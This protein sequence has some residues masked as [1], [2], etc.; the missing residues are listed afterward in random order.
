MT[1]SNV[2]AG[3][4]RWHIEVGDALAVLQSLPAESVG[5]IVT[6]PPYYR[7]RDYGVSGQVG[8]ETT[9]AEYV[10]RLVS[11]L[12]E[13]KRVL[14]S[15]GT[16]WL[17]IGDTWL[18]GEMLGIPWR[19][20]LALQ[21]D[22]WLLR[23]APIWAKPKIAPN[24]SGKRRPMASYEFVF[25]LAKSSSHIYDYEAVKEPPSPATLKRIETAR[26]HMKDPSAR[27]KYDGQRLSSR[28]RDANRVFS[29]PEAL[30]RM[31]QGRLRRDVWTVA[32]TSSRNA[33]VAPF[34]AALVEP[35][36]LAGS[37]KGDIVLDPFAGSGT[38][39]EVALKHGRRFLGIDLNPAYV[40]EIAE[41]RLR[42]VV[43]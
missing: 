9:S 5:C 26:R 17:N 34:P 24:P 18:D 27:Y 32:P 20:A 16:M 10:A 38:T 6:S 12:S 1:L 11:I 7:A 23:S 13:A 37:R 31:E 42:A 41:P 30:T 39:G 25:M 28:N 33:H 40:R 35:C 21:A 15:D 3:D 29:D 19:V 4:S 43:A 8:H 22:G 36:I 2:L 14:R